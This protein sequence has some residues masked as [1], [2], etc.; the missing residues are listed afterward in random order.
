MKS[1]RNFIYIVI[2]TLLVSGCSRDDFSFSKIAST[3]LSNFG[4]KIGDLSLSGIGEQ[5]G[6]V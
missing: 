5:I 2:A 6:I 3:T 4:D 1:I